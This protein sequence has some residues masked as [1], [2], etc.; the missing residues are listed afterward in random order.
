MGR[1][2]LLHIVVVRSGIHMNQVVPVGNK[3]EGEDLVIAGQGRVARSGLV[4]RIQKRKLASVHNVAVARGN[5]GAA[6]DMQ[7]ADRNFNV[8]AMALLARGESE[9][10]SIGL[11]RFP[12]GGEGA[13]GE[14][15]Y[16]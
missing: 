4:V 9:G 12:P 5:N 13:R 16:R 15:I 1:V 3:T 10:D 2:G 7:L 14:G 8:L 11:P 6:D